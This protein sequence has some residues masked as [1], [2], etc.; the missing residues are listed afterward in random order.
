MTK[1]LITAKDS[2]LSFSIQKILSTNIEFHK[3]K[4]LALSHS[5]LDITNFNEVKKTIE[6]YKPSIVINC[7]SF[8]AVDE[9]EIKFKKAYMVN[10][11]GPKNLAITCSQHDCVLVH[12]STDYVFD[13]RKHA[14]YTIAD[15][16]SPL[17]KYGESKLLGEEMVKY[18]CNKF[19]IIRTSWLFGKGEK[20]FLIKMLRLGKEKG[21]LKVASDRISSPSFTDDVA[22]ALLKLTLSFN[23]GIYHITNT[24]FC[25]RYELI[26]YFFEKLNLDI[27]VIPA[28]EE[29]FKLPAR[30]PEFSA[31]DNFP[32][33]DIIGYNLPSWKE[34]V[35]RFIKEYMV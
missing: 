19:F 2:Q 28:K 27:K 35:D 24:G 23:F 29:E 5:Q 32:L 9:C 7:A 18:F 12:I 20:N 16:P 6:E 25:S 26:K 15:K 8:N 31:L 34:G 13:G 22:L 17:S 3:I 10:G 1:I 33:Q 21:F 14:P 11:I 30:R 4:F